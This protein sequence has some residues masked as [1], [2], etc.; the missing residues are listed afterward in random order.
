MLLKN[1]FRQYLGI[2]EREKLLAGASCERKPYGNATQGKAIS[3]ATPT[4]G[5]THIAV[6]ERL[7]GKNV[8]WLEKV[9]DEQYLAGPQSK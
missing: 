9:T 1:E 8:D 3:T 6:Q 2:K 4:T 5:M 7:D